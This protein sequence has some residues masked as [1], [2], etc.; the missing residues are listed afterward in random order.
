MINKLQHYRQQQF[1]LVLFWTSFG[2]TL[3]SEPQ[4]ELQPICL[5]RQT[6]ISLGKHL[7]FLPFLGVSQCVHL[8][9]M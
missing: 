2:L 1:Q 6:D 7:A 9:S 4:S 5:L 8:A 3:Q